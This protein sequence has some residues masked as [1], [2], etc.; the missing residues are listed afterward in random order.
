ML[1]FLAPKSMEMTYGDVPLAGTIILQITLNIFKILECSKFSKTY[2]DSVVSSHIPLP[3]FPLFLMC[4][5][6]MVPLSKLRSQ[7]QHCCSLNFRF[8]L[9]FIIFFPSKALFS[10][11]LPFRNNTELS[12]HGSLVSY[13]GVSVFPCL[14]WL[15][16][17]WGVLVRYFVEWLFI[18]SCLGFLG[19]WLNK[20]YGVSVKN[21]KFPFH[22]VM[23]GVHIHNRL[24]SAI[25]PSITWPR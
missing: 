19:S 13:N 10:S 11:R 20:G 6:N 18:C 21:K 24:G 12:C 4:F 17:F 25:L 1:P 3:Y 5:F 8:Y 23:S 15:E 16:Q 7:P 9:D 14:S 22:R 2:K